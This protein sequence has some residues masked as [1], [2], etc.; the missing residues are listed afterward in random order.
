MAAPWAEAPA[1]RSDVGTAIAVHWALE[2]GAHLD[3]DQ[4][5]ATVTDGWATL[6]GMVDHPQQRLDAERAVLT[7]RGVRGVTNH[8]AVAGAKVS[9]ETVRAAISIALARRADHAAR[10]VRVDVE[11]GTVTLGGTVETWAE[12]QVM[13]DAARQTPGVQ[14]VK[15]RLHVTPGS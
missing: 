14:E 7:V 1:Q 6:E 5:Q 13:I 2:W 10:L 15:D 3:E 11:G 4:V 12:K 8:V 9:P